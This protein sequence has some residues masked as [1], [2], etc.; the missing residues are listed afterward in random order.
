MVLAFLGGSGAGSCYDASAYRGLR[1]KIRGTTPRAD[2]AALDKVV[3]SLVTAETQSLRYGGDLRG[4]GGHFHL[5]VPVQP[6]VAPGRADLGSVPPADL[7]RHGQAHEAGAP[8]LQAIDWGISREVS[9][10]RID[11]DDVELF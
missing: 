8:K 3:I 2:P 4:S 5:E 11:L 7:G 9:S 10:F 1:F 6:R